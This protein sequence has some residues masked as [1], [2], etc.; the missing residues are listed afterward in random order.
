MKKALSLIL[1]LVMALSLAA[2]GGGKT[3]TPSDSNTP[4]DNTSAE[5]TKLSLILRGGTYADVI[6]ECLP[7]FEAEHNVVCE[8]QELSEGDLYSGIALDA[9]NDKG[10]YDLC[11]VDGSW[12]AEFTE[13]GVLANL[14]ELGYSLDED[15]IPAT[16]AICY[17]GDDLYLAPYYGNVTVLLYNKANVEAAGYTGD[18]ILSLEDMLAICEKA[19][20]DGKLGFIYRGDSQNNLVVDFLPILLSYGGWVIDSNNQPTVN[21]PEFKDAMNFYLKLIAT[22]S[23]QV[24]DDLIAS[25]DTGAGTMGV[26]WPGWYTPTADTAAD[27][28]AI[29]GAVAKGGETHNANVY[30]VWTIGIPNNSQN[31]ELATELLSYLMDKDVQK[32]TVPS[33]GVPCRYSS[34]QDAEIL[35]TYPQYEVVCKALEGGMYRPVIAEW[36]QFYTILGAEMDNI[37]NG[38]KTVDQGLADA[39]TKRFGLGM[40]SPTVVIL[41]IMTAYPLFFTLVYS[42]TDYNL[43]RSLKNGSHFIALQNYTKL[44]SDPYFQQSILN[45]VKFTILAVIF[46]MFIGLVMALFVNSLKRGQKTMRTLLLLPYLLPT[47]TVALSWRM[48]LSPN[49]GIV[50]QVLQ[51]LHLPVYNWFSDIHTAFGMLVLID[52]WQSAPFVFLLLYAAL[53]SVPQSQYEAARIDGANRFKILFYVTLPNIKNSLAL[54]ALLRTIDSFRLFDKVNLLTGGGP[55]NSTSTITQYLYNYGIKSLDFGFGSAGA[56]VMTVLVLLLSSVYI[57]RAIS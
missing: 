49:Y 10:S 43:L 16:T 50:N 3:E 22:G 46:E 44:L 21:T 54:C 34:L 2:C 15:V 33:G 36:T 32:S 14:T 53:Q 23:A 51:A 37:V 6:K 47:V 29:T 1:A 4:A 38:V 48:M 42:F 12:M 39:Q 57:K 52:V 9:I 8:V 7:A 13:N 40:L 35:K 24:K 55:A 20:A 19:K 25:C 11:M 28:C 45:T 41:L 5:P 30:G 27:Y 31:K 17:V 56:I 26:G 18:T